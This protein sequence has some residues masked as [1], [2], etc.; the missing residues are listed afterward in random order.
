MEH[1]PKLS[2]AHLTALGCT[3]PELIHIAAGAG[4]DYVSLRT[5]PVGLAGEPDHSLH[6]NPALLRETREAL[7]ATGLEILDIELARIVDGIDVNTYEPAIAAAAALGVKHVL[8]NVW[9][10]G[11]KYVVDS[12][13][14]LSDIAA[15]YGMTVE[16]EF[17]TW[18]NL[19]NLADT[20][21]IIQEANRP[22]LGLLVD[23]LHFNRSRVRLDELDPLPREWF[24]MVHLC[25]GPPGIPSSREELIFTGRQA[26]LDPGMGGIDLASILDRIPEVPYSLEIPNDER[27]KAVGW[28]EHVRLCARNT[29]R[30]LAAHPHPAGSALAHT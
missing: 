15:R 17:V 25:D 6:K 30:Y 28:A 7:E 4:Y 22:N 21:S 12:V 29:R 24:R 18:A 8:S 26:R 13:A 3:P 27:V 20:V 1:R 9:S 5:I 23:T 19:T 2:V 11:H 16:L 14:A 10:S